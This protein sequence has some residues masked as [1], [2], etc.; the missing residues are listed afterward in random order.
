MAKGKKK[1]P[2]DAKPPTKD[3]KDAK[4]VKDDGKTNSDAKK[5]KKDGDSSKTDD[6]KKKA[7][8]CSSCS[9][10]GLT[11]HGQTCKKCKGMG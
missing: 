6:S 2:V 10:L 11:T 4:N 3:A 8:V 1:Q 7:P 5:K 9:G